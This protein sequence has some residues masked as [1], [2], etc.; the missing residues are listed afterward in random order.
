MNKNESKYFNTAKK[1]DDALLTLLE[2]KDYEFITIKD[3]CKEANV[4]RSTF[5]LHYENVADLLS[6]VIENSNEEFNLAFSSIE[7]KNPMYSSKKELMFIKDEYLIPYLTFVKKN[8]KLY[9][10]IKNN[11]SLFDA[12][13]IENDIYKNFIDKILAKYEIENEYKNYYF[14]YFKSGINAIIFRWLSDNCI[15]DVQIIADL[16]KKLVVHENI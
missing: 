7:K 5:Y 15:I 1:M 8:K 2:R 12:D 10:I 6:E 13:K 16:I 4:N 3:I 9:Q 14:D 11:F